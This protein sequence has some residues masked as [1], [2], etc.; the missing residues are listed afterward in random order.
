LADFTT[1]SVHLEK[2]VGEALISIVYNSHPKKSYYL[3]C[4]TGGRQG[5]YS[6]F[7]FPD[8]YDGIV[9]G[10]PATNFN[11]L[12]GS[13]AMMAV[14]SGAT[15]NNTAE[16]IPEHLWALIQNATYA[17]CDLLDG[18][19]DNIV[20]EPDDC[21]FRPEELSCNGHNAGNCL[22][23]TQVQAVRNIYG[24]LYGTHGDFLF[25]GYNLGADAALESAIFFNGQV[26]S[27][28]KVS[29]TRAVFHSVAHDHLSGLGGLRGVQHV[30]RLA[31]LWNPHDGDHR[32]TRPQPCCD[33]RLSRLRSL[34]G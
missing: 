5:M 8:D 7:N 18:V 29:Q 27:Y 6:A 20:S 1:R 10:S 26:F 24:P 3:G 17:Q 33:F 2:L 14:F 34:P 32:R 22:T 9:A 15:T 28:P 13:S 31:Y 4:S 16:A 11:N 30:L 25:P 23:P 12:I 19:K 21:D